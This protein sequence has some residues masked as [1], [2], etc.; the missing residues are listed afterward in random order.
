MRA[1]SNSALTLHC[2]NFGHKPALQSTT[3][4]AREKNPTKCKILESL[5]IVNKK[6]KICNT[7]PSLQLPEVWNLC[8]AAVA[9]QLSKSDWLS[10]L[11]RLIP[12]QTVVRSRYSLPCCSYWRTYV[13]CWHVWSRLAFISLAWFQSFRIFWKSVFF[14]FDCHLLLSYFAFWFR[15]KCGLMK[16]ALCARNVA[17]KGHSGKLGLKNHSSVVLRTSYLLRKNGFTIICTVD[18]TPST[19]LVS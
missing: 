1:A 8:S 3:V 10:I 7:A 11:R 14:A 6:A 13:S 17:S 15:V 9:K 4:L 5:C 12:V 19:L 16:C 18:G 2:A